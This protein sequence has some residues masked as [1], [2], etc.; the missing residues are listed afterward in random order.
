MILDQLTHLRRADYRC[1]GCPNNLKTIILKKTSQSIGKGLRVALCNNS[2]CSLPGIPDFVFWVCQP[3]RGRY[4]HLLAVCRSDASPPRGMK[5]FILGKSLNM[6]HSVRKEGREERGT[7]RR[8]GRER[9]QRLH[10]ESEQVRIS[11]DQ[12][13]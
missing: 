12:C 13:N 5:R 3:T 4:C 1:P 6:G 11:A 2:L 9:K 8:E 7:A 10:A